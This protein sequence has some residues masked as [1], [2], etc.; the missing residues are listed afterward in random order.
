[1][2]ATRVLLFR[3]Q[4]GTV[5]LRD[6]LDDLDE[7]PRLRCLALLAQLEQ[8]GHELRRPAAENLGGGI[9]E[10]RGKVENVN[11]RMLYFFHGRHVVVVSHGF[12]KQRAK[13]PKNEFNTALRR[14]REFEANPRQHTFQPEK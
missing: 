12:T 7:R 5:P 14:K 2:P 10:L 1:M 4:D 6:W 8:F 11:C 9:Y 3:E 13:V